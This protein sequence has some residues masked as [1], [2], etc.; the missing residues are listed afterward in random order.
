M[1]M[2]L[3]ME[4]KGNRDGQWRSSGIFIVSRPDEVLYVFMSFRLERLPVK[5]HP[6]LPHR[7]GH[8]PD[9]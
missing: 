7:I 3:M 4:R 6:G 9:Y 8:P 1:L 5:H 2:L